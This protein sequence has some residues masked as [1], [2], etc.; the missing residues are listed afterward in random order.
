I[1]GMTEIAESHL[2]DGGRVKDCLKKIRL[3]SRHLLGLIN[4]VLDMSQIENGNFH[5][6]EEPI[7]LPEVLRD[8]NM[9]TLAGIRERGQIFDVHVVN[10]GQEQF[11]GD[12]LRLRQILLNLL[13]NAVKF[14]PAGGQIV[15][16]T[17]QLPGTQGERPLIRFVV[18]DTGVG[19]SREFME[20]IFEAF[21]REQDSRTDRIE[22]SGLGMCI[23]K[24]LVDMLGGTVTV[25]SR[26]GVGTTFEVTLPMEPAPVRERPSLPD[27]GVLLV[28]RDP[29]VLEQG[30]RLLEALGVEA[31]GTDNVESAAAMIR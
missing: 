1:A 17:E 11:L 27:M 18:S 22:G 26:P 15:F 4:D 7:S 25:S 12:D 2:Q 14:T 24:R 19:M 28:D 9:I 21:T 30:C 23:T 31:G 3:S 29:V 6:S 20:H 5:I 13:S 8:V 10:L 16:R